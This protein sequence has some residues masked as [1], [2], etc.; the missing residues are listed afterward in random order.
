M[1][2]CRGRFEGSGLRLFLRGLPMWL[3]VIGPLLLGIV[4]AHR[5]R[6]DWN[7]LAPHAAAAA[8]LPS[9][10]ERSRPRLRPLSRSSVALPA[11]WSSVVLAVLL[12]PVFQAMMLRWWLGGL[13]VRRH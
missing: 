7:A 5:S 6:C 10:I 11:S 9:L 4:A 2:I 3:L 1:A 12:F 8:T 13:A